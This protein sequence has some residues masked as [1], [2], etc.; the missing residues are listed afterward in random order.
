MTL[1]VHLY[2]RLWFHI[3]RLCCPYFYLISP[4]FGASGGL[5]FVLVAFP[6]YGHMLLLQQ[7]TLF[8]NYEE[9]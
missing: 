1:L 8:Y 4:S 6:R 7:T 3:R 9:L 5:C 2:V